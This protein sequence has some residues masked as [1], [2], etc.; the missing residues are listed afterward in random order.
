VNQV[1]FP[2]AAN[3]SWTTFHAGD[4][5]PMFQDDSSLDKVQIFNLMVLAGVADSGVWSEATAFCERKRLPDHGSAGA[6]FRRRRAGN[7]AADQGRHARATIP[8]STNSALYFPYLKSTD[9]L[10][11]SPIE[12][13]PSGYVAGIFAART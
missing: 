6:R 7:A 9:P 13:P 11:S 1:A 4:F 10:T 5:A 3:P 8:K 2:N 12:L